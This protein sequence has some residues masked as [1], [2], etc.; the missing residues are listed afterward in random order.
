MTAKDNLIVVIPAY[1]P[2]V[3]FIDYAK[4][5]VQSVKALIVVNDGS[6]EKFD[7]VFGEIASLPNVHYLTYPENHGKGYAL[8]TAF[9]YCAENFDKNDIVVTADC[10][11][12]HRVKDIYSVFTTTAEH[13]EALVL[14]SRDF[15]QPNV[16]ARSKLGNTNIRRIFRLFYGLKIYDCQ[17]GLRG[18]TVETAEKFLRIKGDRFEYEMSMLIFAKK[19]KIPMLEKAIDTVYPENPKDHV[20]HFKT[21]SDSVKVVGACLTNLEWYLISST[22]SAI[23]DVLIFWLLSTVIVPIQNPALNILV[24][25]VTARVGSSIF[26]FIFNFKYVFHGTR[27]SSVFKYYLLWICQ[28][29]A[30]YGL[31]YLFGEVIGWNV[32][33]CKVVCDLVLACVS[34]QIQNHWVFAEKRKKEGRFYGSLARFAKGVFKVVKKD[35]RFNVIK[36]KSPVMYVCRHLNMHAPYVTLVGMP[37]DVHPLSL[38]V[39]FDETQA[40]N[41]FKD[42]TF[43]VRNGKK[44]KKF[45]IKAKV[46]AFVTCKILKSLK[47]VPVY[48]KSAGALTTFR[49]ALN[50]LQQGDNLMVY[51][52]VQYTADGNTVSDIYKGFLKLG[53]MYKN[54][55]GKSLRFVPLYIDD[56]YRTV[57]EKPHVCVDNFATDSFVASEYL[58]QAIN[59]VEVESPTPW[60]M[61]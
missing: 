42:Y 13:P 28:L 9:K 4:Q 23:I 48:R 56:K 7:S 58:K 14:G 20:S 1:E 29:S 32:T 47:G 49:T 57:T 35:Y 26:N 2:P 36:Q 3:E 11:G 37:F 44:P 25:T 8:K 61:P 33:I 17:T 41:H 59:G 34:Y 30:S 22:L 52:D 54:K 18:F 53:E 16:P 31:A 24:A 12:Q 39:F 45:S 38:S 27:K 55:T 60:A 40:Y 51:A 15:N 46:S 5:V 6:N 19:E 50:Y 10:D 43:S 21:F